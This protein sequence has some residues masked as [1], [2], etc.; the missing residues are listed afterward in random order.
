MDPSQIVNIV[1][2]IILI[3]LSSFFSCTETAFL[4]ANK[5]R[6]R[7]LAEEGDRRAKK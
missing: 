7:N 6:M 4:S 3:C 5:I 2:F 1:V